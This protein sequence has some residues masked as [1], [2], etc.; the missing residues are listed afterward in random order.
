MSHRNLF[1]PLIEEAVSEAENALRRAGGTIGR[2]G[3]GAPAQA[4]TRPG[5]DANGSTI[6]LY[7]ALTELDSTQG[8]A[9]T[10]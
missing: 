3:T 4:A 1:R 9:C 6:T 10:S 5:I 8:G 7:P 2:P